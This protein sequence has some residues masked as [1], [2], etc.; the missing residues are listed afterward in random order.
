MPSWFLGM[1]IEHHEGAVEMAQVE[2]EEGENP[3]AVALAKKII[4]DQEAEITHM[5]ELLDS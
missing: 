4:S 1:M 2:V 5:R 3:D